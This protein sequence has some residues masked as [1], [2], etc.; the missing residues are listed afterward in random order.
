MDLGV[1]TLWLSPFYVSPMKDFGYDIS[2]FTDVDPIFGTLKDFGDLIGEMK[3]KGRHF[4]G[5]FWE[6][7][8]KLD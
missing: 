2:D 8:E 1:E 7:L 4:V 3:Q 5:S 6:T